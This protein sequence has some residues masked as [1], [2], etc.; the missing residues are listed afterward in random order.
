ML[1]TPEP[2]EANGEGRPKLAFGPAGQVYVTFTRPSAKPHT[3]DIRFVRA[4]AA[5]TDW[6][7]P[8]TVQRDRTVTGH[9]FDSLIVDRNGRIFVAW[10]DKRDGDRARAT[11]L[12]YR[13]AA[14]YYAV[15]SDDGR[16][17]AVEAKLADHCCECCRI[18][19]S[20]NE[21]G[22]VVAMWRHIF[23]PNVRDHALAVLHAGGKP[24]ALKRASFDD[25]R[26][27]ACPHHGPSL[28]FDATG[29]RH[30]VWFSAGD[31][32]GVFYAAAPG[33]TP[34]SP[35]RLGSAQAGHG[36]V[37]AAGSTIAAAW[38]DFDGQATRVLSRHSTD[39]GATWHERVLASTSGN[40]DHPHL[41]RRGHDIIRLV[42]HTENEAIVVRRIEGQS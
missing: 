36:E 23:D 16:S 4:G 22:E 19:L 33:G 26:I 17:F 39:G 10:I 28:D 41:V 24:G 7:D 5:G 13:G 15:S 3:G 8:I 37:L 18:A 21:E 42:W 29:R 35:V 27:D 25:W 6:S 20:L 31:D 2:V 11:G 34:G 38:K 12:A 40:S 1:R 14:I 9:R 32:G 30:Q